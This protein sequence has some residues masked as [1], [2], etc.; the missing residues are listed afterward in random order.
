MEGPIYYPSI[1]SEKGENFYLRWSSA[2]SP[3][4][5]GKFID[6]PSDN[7]EHCVDLLILDKENHRHADF[8][9]VAQQPGLLSG[10][11]SSLDSEFWKIRLRVSSDSGDSEIVELV[12]TC[13]DRDPGKITVEFRHPHGER[14]LELQKKANILSRHEADDARQTFVIPD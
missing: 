14:I 2:E 11:S 9:S 4:D 10:I 13:L 6:L 12:T 3:T 1:S 8:C 5:D 7:S